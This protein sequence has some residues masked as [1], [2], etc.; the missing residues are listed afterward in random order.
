MK[1]CL[2]TAVGRSSVRPAVDNVNGKFRF[3]DRCVA[4]LFI[5]FPYWS[6]GINA[7]ISSPAKAGT[8]SVHA[9]CCSDHWQSQTCSSR[10]I[11]R[12]RSQ[13]SSTTAT[14]TSHRPIKFDQA[15]RPQLFGKDWKCDSQKKKKSFPLF[16]CLFRGIE[17]PLV[18][19]RAQW[20]SNISKSWLKKRVHF[21]T[22]Y[23]ERISAAPI[24]NWNTPQVFLQ[25]HSHPGSIFLKLRHPPGLLCSRWPFHVSRAVS[26]I[27]VVSSGEPES[28]S[29]THF[30]F[31]FFSPQARKVSH[32]MRLNES[33]EWQKPAS[34]IASHLKPLFPSDLL[35]PQ[36]R[37]Q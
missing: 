28:L 5:Y 2:Q 34:K 6:R 21:R 33:V 9:Q 18:Q 11:H 13:S 35:I 26:E 37:S 24:S 31:S 15:R 7:L 36:P 12:A 1:S 29:D 16:I 23:L 3:L 27:T 8:C 20:K 30:F 25:T 10:W 17:W 4:Y 14:T 32:N 22:P 19:Y